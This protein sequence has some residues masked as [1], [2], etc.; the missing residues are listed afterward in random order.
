MLKYVLNPKGVFNV[1]V[2][3]ISPVSLICSDNC[4]QAFL[5]ALSDN[6]YT[7]AV[8]RLCGGRRTCVRRSWHALYGDRDTHC[9]A[10]AV[11][12]PGHCK[13]GRDAGGDMGESVEKD[14]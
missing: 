5:C 9:M 11:R 14:L 12:L 8:S 3:V 10:A 7:A 1:K 4:E 6:D 13:G 2:F